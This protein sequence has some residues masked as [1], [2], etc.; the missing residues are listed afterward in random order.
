MWKG[1]LE[2]PF[3]LSAFYFC[4]QSVNRVDIFRTSSPKA[5]KSSEWEEQTANKH[6]KK[7]NLTRPGMLMQG[8][9]FT[10]QGER[11]AGHKQ[12]CSPPSCH[13]PQYRITPWFV[14]AWLWICFFFFFFI[15]EEKNDLFFLPL[16]LEE[17]LNAAWKECSLPKQQINSENQKKKKK[18]TK[19]LPLCWWCIQLHDVEEHGSAPVIAFHLYLF[20]W[21]MLFRLVS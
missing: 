7:V 20:V 18:T 8:R 5:L 1:V 9:H 10:F 13:A 11:E 16:L 21:Q 14:I 2:R 19:P 12:C 15:S 6:I 4:E 17:G 3:F